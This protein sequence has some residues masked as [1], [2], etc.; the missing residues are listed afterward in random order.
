MKSLVFAR[1]WE[2]FRQYEISFSLALTISWADCK[3]DELQEQIN[4]A[5][6][7]AFNYQAVKKLKEVQ[8]CLIKKLSVLKSQI[9]LKSP[10]GY[11]G[12]NNDGAKYYYGVGRY[13]G[14]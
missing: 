13:S 2:L 5:E 14:D 3:A 11:V 4:I 9:K 1:A 10:S 12:S 6:S 8:Y 7:M